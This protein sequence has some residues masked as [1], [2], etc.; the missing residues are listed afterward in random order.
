MKKREWLTAAAVALAVSAC[1]PDAMP[2]AAA[3]GP[4]LARAAVS[5]RLKTYRIPTDN[6][7][8]RD[9]VL[10]SDGAMWFT[11]SRLEVSQIGRLDANG[12]FTEFLV[13]SLEGQPSD[14]VSGPDGALWFTQPSGF[15]DAYIV[16]V[17]TGGEFTKFAPACDSLFG[18][19]IAPSDIAVGSDGNLWFTEGLRNQIG[20]LTPAG[21]FT[22][23]TVPTAGAGPTGITAGPDGALWFTEFQANQIGRIDPAT[24]VITEFGTSSGGGWRI[25]AGADGQLYFTIPFTSSIG[26]LDPA[27]GTITEFALETPSQP[28][29]IVLGPDGNVWFTEYLAEQLSMITPDGVVTRVQRIR[30]GPWGI[31]V[32]ADNSIWV[33]LFDDNKLASF[34]LR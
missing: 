9:I 2:T 33:T 4:E 3:G 27:T 18:C 8:P 30:G 22:F 28:R 14:I 16:R 25:A 13:P 34:T 31:G 12:E 19:S 6:T 5:G 21:E 24:G 11:E 15:P 10:G 7:Q 32:G 1:A 23:Y 20:R 29:G 26:R 17:T